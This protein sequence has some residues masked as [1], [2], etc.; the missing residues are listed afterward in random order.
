MTSIMQRVASPRAVTSHVAHRYG[1]WAVVTGA[2]DGIGRA[3]ACELAMLGLDVVLV[4]RR[5]DVLE[6]LGAALRRAYGTDVRVVA[7]DL[8]EPSGVDAVLEAT[9]T[10]RRAP[11]LQP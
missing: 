10:A 11:P 3:F 8:A 1:P 2:S 6:Q 7:A 5:R 9:R 4:A